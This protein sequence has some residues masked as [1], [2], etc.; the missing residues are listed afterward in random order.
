LTFDLL[1]LRSRRVVLPDGVAPAAAHIAGERIA[2]IAP[3]DDVPH[4]ARLIDVGDLVVMPGLVDTHVHL[5]E[6]GRT[7]WE[8]FETGTR[9]AAAG[10]VTTVVDMPLNSVPATTSRDALTLK[11]EAAAGKC[12]V[13]A[14]FWGGVVPGNAG[15]LAPLWDAGVLGFKAFLVPSGVPEFTHVERPDLE[16]AMPTLA[17]LRAPLLAHAEVPGPI[18]RAHADAP[19][20]GASAWR[21]YATYLASRPPAAEHDA[22]AMLLELARKH[23][24][25]VHIVHLSA[26]DTVDLLRRAR[27][28]GVAVSVE[29]CPH[30]LFFAAEDIGDGATSFKCA[31]PI[32]DAANAHRLWAALRD[33]VIDLIATD[34]S[35]SPPAMKCPDSGDFLR[36]WGG[37]AS[38]QLGLAAVWSAAR[39]R[40]H[41]VTDVA[42]WMCAAPAR[43][44]GLDRRKG[45]LAPGCDADVV[46]WDPDA[47]FDVDPGSLYHRHPLTPYAG[48]RLHGVVHETWL[49]GT[50]IYSRDEGIIGPPRG[51]LLTR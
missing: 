9:A 23:G 40:G 7:E 6:P 43:L 1:V 5:N 10:G 44:A 27:V 24:A 36:A 46:V 18:A 33:G 38:L 37:I 42:R 50:R 22:I 47:A 34:H 12:S 3:F 19:P 8:G 25:R 41:Q 51:R 28:E 29:T 45:L 39:E 14:G 26:S 32:R 30:Y 49:R 16:A 2:A 4:G 17:Q 15:E 21:A 20:A 31:P 11:R 35:P 13:D 48:R